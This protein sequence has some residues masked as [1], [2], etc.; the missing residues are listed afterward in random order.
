[1]LNPSVWGG[2]EVDVE[3]KSFM[4]K[5]CAGPSP[6]DWGRENRQLRAMGSIYLYV[7]QEEPW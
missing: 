2:D 7:F 3:K 4:G 6:S 1:M 5:L